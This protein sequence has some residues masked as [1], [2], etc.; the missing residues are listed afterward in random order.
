[1]GCPEC[2]SEN[3]IKANVNIIYCTDCHYVGKGGV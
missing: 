2:K 1:M 3:V